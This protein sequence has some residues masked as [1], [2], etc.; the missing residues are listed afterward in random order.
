MPK[1][2]AFS[3]IK[4]N[5]TGADYLKSK[6]SVLFYNSVNNINNVPT[7]VSSYK[8][9]NL[10]TDGDYRRQVEI[11]KLPAFNKSAL[12]INLHSQ[13]DLSD[14]AVISRTHTE[15]DVSK[16]LVNFDMAIPFYY[17]YSIDPS[18]AVVQPCS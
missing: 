4:P 11:G 6:K 2:S 16:N 14:V 7:R 18:G 9:M 8:M 13:Y 3:T 15:L 10:F 1:H 12:A 5:M 17:F